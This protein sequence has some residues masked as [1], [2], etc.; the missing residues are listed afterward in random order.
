[1]PIPAAEHFTPE[2]LQLIEL[3]ERSLHH[4]SREIKTRDQ[5]IIVKQRILLPI[6][7]L[8]S[9]FGLQPTGRH[10]RN[11]LTVQIPRE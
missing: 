9:R 2:M 10:T 7:G 1:M 11:L 4:I 8:N 5:A 6:G 3:V